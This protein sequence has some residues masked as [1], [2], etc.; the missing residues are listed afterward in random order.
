MDDK[1]E[2]GARPIKRAIQKAI[3]D[4]LSD[5]LLNNMQN[6]DKRHI[7]VKQGSAKNK[8]LKFELN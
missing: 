2:F 1:R 6:T 5:I 4:P 8:E 3:E 7:T